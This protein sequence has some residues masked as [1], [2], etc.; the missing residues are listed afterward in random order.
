V[1]RKS[2]STSAACA[3]A[4]YAEAAYGCQQHPLFWETSVFTCTGLNRRP[5]S[6]ARSRAHHCGP[7][8]YFCC[9]VSKAFMCRVST[10]ITGSSAAVNALTSHCD[11]GRLRSRFRRRSHRAKV[12]RGD[13]ILRS[14]RTSAPRSPCRHRRQRTPSFL[15]RHIKTTE[16]RHLIAPSSMLEVAADHRSTSSSQK[17]TRDSSSSVSRSRRDTPSFKADH[18][19]PGKSGMRLSTQ[20][21]RPAIRPA[22][23]LKGQLSAFVYLGVNG[24]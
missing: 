20:L 9:A 7:S 19:R 12:R 15:H 5:A 17:G 3:E 16:M 21:S 10:Q 23:S 18:H 11:S 4:A 14:V 6:S 1:P 24:G 13:D 22:R 8:C 2:D